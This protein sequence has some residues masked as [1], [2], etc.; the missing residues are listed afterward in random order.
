MKTMLLTAAV[1]ALATPALAQSDPG[2]RLPAAPSGSLASGSVGAARA[3]ARS[4]V[5]PTPNAVYDEYGHLIGADPDPNIRTQLYRE[6]DL[7]EGL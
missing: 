3:H 4:A 6:H 7:R 1:L 5:N 2:M